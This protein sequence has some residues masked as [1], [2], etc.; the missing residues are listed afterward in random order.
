MAG[1]HRPVA[2]R[3]SHPPAGMPAWLLQGLQL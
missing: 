1:W 2:H 3:P